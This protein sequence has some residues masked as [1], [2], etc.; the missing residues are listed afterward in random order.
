LVLDIFAGSNT[1]GRAAERLARQWL[2]FDNSP[3]YLKAS[4]FRFI[5]GMPVGA[6]EKIL[7]K[8]E[9]PEAGLVLPHDGVPFETIPGKRRE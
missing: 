8:L 9:N 3:E 6:T 5:E 2:S 7:G 4:V 1:T